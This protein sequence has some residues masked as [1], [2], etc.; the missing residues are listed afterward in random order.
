LIYKIYDENLYVATRQGTIIIS[1]VNDEKGSS[2]IHTLKNGDR[3]FTPVEW[4]EKG[5]TT[6]IKY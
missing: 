4:I 2:L 3:F 5:M 1:G 6:K